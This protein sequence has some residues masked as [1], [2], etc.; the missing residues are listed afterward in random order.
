MHRRGRVW[1]YPFSAKNKQQVETMKVGTT[2]RVHNGKIDMIRGT[3]R[4]AVDQWGLLK[5]DPG[6][7]GFAKSRQQPF[8]GRVRACRKHRLV[9]DGRIC[10]RSLH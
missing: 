1:G 6:R 9:L 10:T 4:L 3:M 2:V 5:E 7:G 8:A